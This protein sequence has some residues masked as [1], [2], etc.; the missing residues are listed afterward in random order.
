MN[1][2]KINYILMMKKIMCVIKAL[3]FF[4]AMLSL[5][6]PVPTHETGTPNS[7]SSLSR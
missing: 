1:Y 4:K 5:S 6:G 3:N 2:I 7:Y